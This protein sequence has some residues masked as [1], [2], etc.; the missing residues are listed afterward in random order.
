M[1]VEIINREGYR[2][3][4]LTVKAAKPFIRR[5]R[6]DYEIINNT[7]VYDDRKEDIDGTNL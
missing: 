2:W 4:F 6:G 5:F 7:R 1:K 3:T